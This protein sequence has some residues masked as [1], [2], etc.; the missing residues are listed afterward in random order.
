MSRPL[1]V[2]LV[3]R[4]A[5]LVRGGGE[6]FD[7]EMAGRL[8]GLGVRTSL[9]TGLPLFGGATSPIDHPRV[10]HVRSPYTGWFPW[11][12]VWQGWRLRVWDFRCFERRAAAWAVRHQGEFDLLQ[13]CEMPPLID[14]LRRAGWRK[15]I[16]IRATAFD[17]H[18]PA[19]AVARADAAIAGGA[20][21]PRMRA[22]CGREVVDIP[23][24]VDTEH[25]RPGPSPFRAEQGI[26]PDAFLVLCVARLQQVKNHDLLLQA[27][28]ELRRVEAKAVLALIG[29][30]PL[31]RELRRRAVA[32]ATPEAVRF[33]GERPY[34]QVAEAYRAADVH[35]LASF[36]ESFSFAT[37]EAMA[38]GLPCVVTET[39]WIPQLI[40]R[41]AGGRVTPNGDAAAFARALHELAAD[42]ALRARLGAHNR[43]AAVERHGW[44]ASARKLLGLY[45]ELVKRPAGSRG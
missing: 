5:S 16:V 44:E 19:G 8:E 42:P 1:R 28:A 36:H 38:S 39:E 29:S 21:V 4:M 3:N 22:R 27:F 17:Y 15:P 18:D 2:L 10:H 31:E 37:L 32:L 45:E 26:P 20:T 30:G 6:T 35:A 25:F 14:D 7:L 23:N 43:A 24:G 34:A 41:E 9:L 40:G 13:I 33:L 12:R 11:D